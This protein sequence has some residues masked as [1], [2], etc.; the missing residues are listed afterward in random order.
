MEGLLNPTTGDWGWRVGGLDTGN[1]HSRSRCQTRD[2]RSSRSC[3]CGRNRA[4]CCDNRDPGCPLPKTGFDPQIRYPTLSA[5]PPRPI[6]ASFTTRDTSPRVSCL[7][8]LLPPFFAS[9]TRGAPII[10]NTGFYTAWV[11]G[12]V[13]C[14]NQRIGK[15]RV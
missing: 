13:Y 6:A 7:G 8:F 11:T 9:Y 10:V 3:R 14:T 15:P 12:S 4:V 2:Q 1:R 5:Q